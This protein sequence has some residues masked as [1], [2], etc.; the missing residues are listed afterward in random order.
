MV[1]KRSFI[2][3]VFRVQHR[4]GGAAFLTHGCSAL[5]SSCGSV[6]FLK[7]KGHLHFVKAGLLCPLR[8]QKIAL[9]GPCI[10]TLG[11]FIPFIIVLLLF[12][13]CMIP[14]SLFLSC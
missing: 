2:F 8:Q 7:V 5:L 3:S 12:Q 9:L 11:V 4:S 1:G 13:N 10:Y 14:A 6:S